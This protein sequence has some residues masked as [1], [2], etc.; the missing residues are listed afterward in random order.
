MN[1]MSSESKALSAPRKLSNIQALRAFAALSVIFFHLVENAHKHGMT[2]V[3]LTPLGWWGNSG[4]DIFFVI[5]GFVMIE[6]QRRKTTKVTAF[7]I[8]RIVRIAPLYWI[9]TLFYWG[10]ATLAPSLF[11]NLDLSNAWLLTSLAFVSGVFSFSAPILGQ[12]WTLEFEM[13]FYLVFAFALNMR[14]YFKTGILTILIVLF[15]VMYFDANAI[16][17]EFCFGVLV[18]LIYARYKPSRLLSRIFLGIGLAGFLPSL[19]LG[20]GSWNR[21]LVYGIPAC[22]LVLGLVTVRQTR[23]KFFMTLGDSSY[24]AYLFQFFAIPFLFRFADL[25]PKI[26]SLTD[27]TIVI[28]AIITVAAGQLLYYGVEKRVTLKLNSILHL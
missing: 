20:S 28:F 12:G 9:L 16:I 14:N 7:L 22:F 23:N 18:G 11:P 25:I 5:S 21:A 6:S 2:P 15:I 26:P 10:L 3:A 27:I 24:S 4:V 1:M 8:R 13:L 17:L 19:I